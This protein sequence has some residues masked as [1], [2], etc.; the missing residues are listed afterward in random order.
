[1]K[2]QLILAILVSILLLVNVVALVGYASKPAQTEVIVANNTVES[3]Y[4]DTAIKADIS[5]NKLELLEDSDWENVAIEMATADMEE[6]EYRN[7]FNAL[8]V[9]GYNGSIIE[10]ED[11]SKVVIRDS[12]V[13]D[14][15]VDEQ[16]A[17]VVQELKVYFEDVNGDD[18]KVYLNLTTVIE[19]NEVDSADYTIS[20]I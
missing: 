15:D 2:G 13:I 5:V 18:V 9:R 14:S 20:V 4:N 7:V 16:D 12:D 8:I 1:M 10:K 3:S 19:D 11:I 6:K 17:V